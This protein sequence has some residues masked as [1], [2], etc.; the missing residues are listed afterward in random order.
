MSGG[1]K[2]S[3]ILKRPTIVGGPVDD[4]MIYSISF[5]GSS[6]EIVMHDLAL[7]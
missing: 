5:G 6:P 4:S 2:F 3:L 1:G 7:S